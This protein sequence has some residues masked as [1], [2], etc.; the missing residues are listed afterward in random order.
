MKMEN[1]NWIIG[2]GDIHTYRVGNVTYEV[3]S[4][5]EKLHHDEKSENPTLAHRIK[6][7]LKNDVVPLTAE[8]PPDMMAPEYVCSAAGKED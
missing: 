7:C 4:H 2:I 1:S 3:S 5:F 8:E 6:R